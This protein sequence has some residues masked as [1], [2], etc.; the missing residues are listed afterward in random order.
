MG[1]EASTTVDREGSAGVCVLREMW[2]DD[3][4]SSD[5][6]VSHVLAIRD[7]LVSMTDLVQ[8]NVQGAQKQQK[9]WY[10][11]TAHTREF[12]LGDQVLTLLPTHGNKLKASWQGPYQ[13]LR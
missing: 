7:K 1:A 8:G 9:W 2:E 12:H 13:V 6:L 5:S 3:S 11:R 4:R 10:D